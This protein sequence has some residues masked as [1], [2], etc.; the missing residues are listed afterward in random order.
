MCVCVYIYIYIYNFQI[1]ISKSKSAI[2]S[3]LSSE[4]W[5][6]VIQRYLTIN[7]Y[8]FYEVANSYDLTCTILYDL[9]KPQWREGLGAGLDV[10]NSYK[11]LWIVQLIKYVRWWGCMNS[12]EIA[13][14]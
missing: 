12:Y 14:S 3:I 13:T 2:G 6:G 11:F 5:H 10:G 1:V 4:K 7:S 9:S 8:I